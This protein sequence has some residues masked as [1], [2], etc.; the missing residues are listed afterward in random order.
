MWFSFFKRSTFY[1]FYR[2]L[3]LKDNSSLDQ[4]KEKYS[5]LVKKYHPDKGEND[6]VKFEKVRKA[7]KILKEHLENKQ[8]GYKL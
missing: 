5:L 7:Y 3:G 8:K 4:V 6:V 2:T 1:E